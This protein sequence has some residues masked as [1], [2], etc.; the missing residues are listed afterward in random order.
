MTD[1]KKR[2]TKDKSEP[3]IPRRRPGQREFRERLPGRKAP[4]AGEVGSP[5]EVKKRVTN[6]WNPPPPK[7]R[8]GK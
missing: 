6:T 2:P 3:S 8:K 4:A 1:E 5:G 7:K